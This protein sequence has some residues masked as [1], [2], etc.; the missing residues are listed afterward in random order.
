[1]EELCDEEIK[2]SKPKCE[3][4]KDPE[5]EAKVKRRMIYEVGSFIEGQIERGEDPDIELIQ[6]MEE[7]LDEG[8]SDE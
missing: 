4:D 8:G 1:M 2:L 5:L 7:L 3:D 6:H